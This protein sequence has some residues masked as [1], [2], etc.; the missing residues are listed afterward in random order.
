MTETMI[1]RAERMVRHSHRYFLRLCAFCERPV[2]LA[3]TPVTSDARCE[4]EGELLRLAHERAGTLGRPGVEAPCPDV[5]PDPAPR[6][7]GRARRAR[8]SPVLTAA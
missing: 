4:H 1:L 6:R 2:G 5:D 8:R 7:G 3:T